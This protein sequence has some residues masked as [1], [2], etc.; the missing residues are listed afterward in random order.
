MKRQLILSLVVVPL[1]LAGAPTSAQTFFADL[2]TKAGHFS[3]WRAE[4]LIDT[5]G[6]TFEAEIVQAYRDV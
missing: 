5:K 6:C 3:T 2:D 4:K 1:H